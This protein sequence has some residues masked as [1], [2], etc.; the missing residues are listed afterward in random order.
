MVNG[1]II[2][3]MVYIDFQLLS[4]FFYT[5]IFPNN[6]CSYT[7]ADI[8]VKVFTMPYDNLHNFIGDE[9]DEDDDLDDEDEDFDEG[10]GGDLD[11]YGS[12]KERSTADSASSSS[13]PDKDLPAGSGGGGRR[14]VDGSKSGRRK[15]KRGSS[16]VKVF[17]VTLDSLFGQSER[18][19]EGGDG[20]STSKSSRG[21]SK[22]LISSLLEQLMVS[23]TWL[24]V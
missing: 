17:H 10:D 4:N 3:V 24:K 18:E 13:H 14:G 8:K 2:I 9:D 22:V 11:A 16:D 20:E 15:G 7:A 19:E 1:A 23:L 12:P 6:Y 5:F 21:N